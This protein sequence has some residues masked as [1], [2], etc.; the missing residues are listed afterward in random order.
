M[1]C[2]TTRPASSS[3]VRPSTIQT[4]G[5]RVVRTHQNILKQVP[6]DAEVLSDLFALECHREATHVQLGG[7]D[8]DTAMLVKGLDPSRVVVWVEVETLRGTAVEESW[9]APCCAL[10]RCQCLLDGDEE[11]CGITHTGTAV[12]AADV[13]TEAVL[14]SSWHGKS[15]NIRCRHGWCRGVWCGHNWRSHN[16]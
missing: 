4:A 16:W 14:P 11:D 1:A 9:K 13:A 7:A 3:S 15:G 8:E 10:G 12:T 2:R 5:L 6:L